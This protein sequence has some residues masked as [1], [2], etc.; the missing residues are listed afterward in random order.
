MVFLLVSISFFLLTNKTC[1]VGA[2]M[3]G[4]KQYL[5]VFYYFFLV[6]LL[7]IASIFIL[8]VSNLDYPDKNTANKKPYTFK[9]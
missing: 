9:Q 8:Q 4:S 7:S 5:Q 1:L 2:E 3:S 6:F